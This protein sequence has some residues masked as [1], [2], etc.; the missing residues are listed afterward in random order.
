MEVLR[1]PGPA[2]ARRAT[3]AAILLGVASFVAAFWFDHVVVALFALVLLGLTV[4]RVAGL[5][6]GVQA[7]AGLTFLVSAWAATLDWYEQVASLDLLA[8]ALGNGLLAVVLVT[9]L[10]RLRMVPMP[11]PGLAAGAGVVVVTVAVGFAVG[12]L[13]EVGEWWGHTHLDDAIQVGYDDTI[14]DLAA[15]GF[16]SL[17]AGLVLAGPGRGSLTTDRVHRG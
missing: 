6:G 16:G 5:H 17:L 4:P 10:V 12:V 3:D 14:G 9:G 13:W 15:G 1:V 2:W 11:G 7:A 8:H